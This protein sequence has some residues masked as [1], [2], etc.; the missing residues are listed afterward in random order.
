MK[1]KYYLR[2]GLLGC[3]VMLNGCIDNK[4]LTKTYKDDFKLSIFHVNDTHSHI[5]SERMK[6]KINGKKTY[7]DV[8][9][10][11]RIVTKLN[12]LKQQKPNSLVLNAGDTFQGTLYY[13]LF[14][15]DADA[16]ALNLIKWDAYELGNH[17]FDDG[18]KGLK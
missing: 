3:L 1:S 14:R 16:T 18:D 6:F 13:S 4:N 11:A 12:E 5:T 7:F 17:E 8:G 2:A 10:Y 9:G 15:G